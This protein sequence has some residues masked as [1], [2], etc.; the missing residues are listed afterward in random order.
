MLHNNSKKAASKG[1][2]GAD[3][4]AIPLLR[5]VLKA[6]RLAIESNHGNREAVA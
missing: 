2:L 4:T 3:P 6:G 1:K 5:P